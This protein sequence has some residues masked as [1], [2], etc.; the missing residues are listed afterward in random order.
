MVADAETLVTKA[1]N[2][3]GFKA[4]SVS[5]LQSM[6]DRIEKKVQSVAMATLLAPNGVFAGSAE[7]LQAQ[8]MALKH[9]MEK[10]TLQIGSLIEVVKSPLFFERALQTLS[11]SDINIPAHLKAELVKKHCVAALEDGNATKQHSI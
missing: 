1:Q 11:E 8:G 3:E 4:L 9:K 6:S 2:L 10:V 5:K 7:T